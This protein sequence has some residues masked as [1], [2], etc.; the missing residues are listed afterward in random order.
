MNGVDISESESRFG[1]DINGVAAINGRSL[2]YI[3]TEGLGPNCM[4][5]PTPGFSSIPTKSR[6]LSRAGLRGANPTA[7]IEVPGVLHFR[8]LGSQ[9]VEWV[10]GIQASQWLSHGVDERRAV[11]NRHAHPVLVTPYP[12]RVKTS[13]ALA[14]LQSD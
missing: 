10:G 3:I 5:L 12:L 9:R 8:G 7:R 1:A 14:R 13:R 11:P 2:Q 4:A 6:D